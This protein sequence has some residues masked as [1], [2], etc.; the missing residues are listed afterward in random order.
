MRADGF[1]VEAYDGPEGRGLLFPHDGAFQPLARCRALARCAMDEGATLFEH[2]RATDIAHGTVVTPHGRVTCAHVI[3]AVDGKLD[4][5]FPELAG[6]VRTTRLQ[7]I[8]TAPLGEL[9]FPRPVYA[10]W[11]YDYWQQL[12]DGRVVLGG[13]RDR[14]EAEEWTTDAEPSADLQRCLDTLLRERLGVS[15]P[16][17]HRWAASVSYTEEG[18]PVCTEVRPGVWAIGAYNGTGNVIGALYGRMVAQMVVRGASD[19]ARVFGVS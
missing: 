3:V 6:R 13:C 4:V 5:L 16:I 8:G 1:D 11:G 18:L 14:F 15:A 10:R 9:R 12:P 7:M 2:T 17:T 19:L